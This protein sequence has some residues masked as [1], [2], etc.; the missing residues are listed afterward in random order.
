MA[1][2]HLSYL[3]AGIALLI[4]VAASLDILVAILA[5]SPAKAVVYSR[6]LLHMMLIAMD[7]MGNASFLSLSC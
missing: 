3:L 1:Y 6:A 2:A 5:G 4:L 7:L